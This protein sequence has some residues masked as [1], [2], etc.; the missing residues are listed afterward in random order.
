M[1]ALRSQK[2]IPVVLVAI[3][4]ALLGLFIYFFAERP[5]GDVEQVTLGKDTHTVRIATTPESRTQGLS[6]VAYL[7]KFQGLLL[8]FPYEAPHGIWMKDMEIPIDILWLNNDKRV[9]YIV[10]N[11]SPEWSTT[12]IMKPSEPALYVIELPAGAVA[13]STISVGDTAQFSLNKEAL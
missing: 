4:V 10:E 1:T 3:S 8:A 12:K 11:A 5:I 9:V 6:G 13:R 2:L 7:G